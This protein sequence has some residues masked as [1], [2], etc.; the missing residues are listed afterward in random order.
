[1][2]VLQPGEVGIGLRRDA[3]LMNASRFTPW[4]LEKC[5]GLVGSPNVTRLLVKPAHF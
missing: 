3:E 1:M 2:K 4:L 5:F